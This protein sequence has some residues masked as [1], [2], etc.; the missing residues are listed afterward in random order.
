MS[1]ADELPMAEPTDEGR[2]PDR[3]YKPRLPGADRLRRPP[4]RGAAREADRALGELGIARL[5]CA[6]HAPRGIEDL[7]ERFRHP[8]APPG[9]RRPGGHGG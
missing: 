9:G 7:P 6:P 1:L 4:Q 5:P 3:R 8:L 2:G